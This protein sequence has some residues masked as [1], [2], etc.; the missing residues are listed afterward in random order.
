MPIIT[1]KAGKINRTEEKRLKID[2]KLTIKDWKAAVMAESVEKM[3][4]EWKR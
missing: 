1:K 4:G 3:K 2:E